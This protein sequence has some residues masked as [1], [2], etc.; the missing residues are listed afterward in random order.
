MLLLQ[1]VYSTLSTR[2]KRSLAVSL[3]QP[4]G[5][6]VVKDL[7]CRADVL[8]EPFRPGVMERLGLSPAVL[9]ELNPRL[10]YAR[11]TG[12]GQTGSLAHRAGHD[13]NYLATA[14]VLS[15]RAAVLAPLPH[16]PPPS[17]LRCWVGTVRNHTPPSTW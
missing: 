2:G 16:P 9:L 6:E 14:G 11:L 8:L 7:C 17:P 5:V 10:V 4:A 12:F 3:K 13:I 1:C 15:V